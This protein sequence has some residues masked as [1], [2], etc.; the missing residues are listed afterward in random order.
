M[1]ALAHSIQFA[2]KLQERCVSDGKLTEMGLRTWTDGVEEINDLIVAT[3]KW[4]AAQFD[5][6]LVHLSMIGSICAFR[7]TASRGMPWRVR[8]G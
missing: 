3:R 2:Q 5:D 6:K 7:R 1:A 8:F 4:Q